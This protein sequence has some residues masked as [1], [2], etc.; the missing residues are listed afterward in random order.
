MDPV[1]LVTSPL[2][3]SCIDSSAVATS[4]QDTTRLGRGGDNQG[5]GGQGI[6]LGIP[7]CVNISNRL[8]EF[9]L[10]SSDLQQ[11]LELI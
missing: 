9:V 5:W 7:G 3:S 8:E 11:G 10:G 2:C 1:T 4:G 6:S